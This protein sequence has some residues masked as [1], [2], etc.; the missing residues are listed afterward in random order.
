MHKICD[1]YHNFILLIL[2]IYKLILFYYFKLRLLKTAYKAKELKI[3]YFT[4]SIVISPHKNYELIKGL[5][6]HMAEHID[7]IEYVSIDFKKKNGFLNSNKLAKELGL[8]RQNYCGCKF[9]KKHLL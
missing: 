1:F 3:P 9:A 7:S 6:E 2:N 5:G 8:Y 4:T